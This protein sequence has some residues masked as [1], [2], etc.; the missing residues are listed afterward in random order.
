M[1]DYNMTVPLP[2]CGNA[3]DYCLRN[4]GDVTA[5]KAFP[6][7]VRVGLKR[8]LLDLFIGERRILN[9]TIDDDFSKVIQGYPQVQRIVFASKSKKLPEKMKIEQLILMLL[10][11]SI[12]TFQVQFDDDVEKHKNP[13]IVAR[14]NIDTE[15]ELC[16]TKDSHW[17]G[18]PVK[19]AIL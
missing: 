12:L 3:C 15:G 14:L 8:V 13:K 16:V 2:A 5:N 1:R 18:I 19:D 4:N 10:V 6:S 11:S 9:P 7:V 17:I